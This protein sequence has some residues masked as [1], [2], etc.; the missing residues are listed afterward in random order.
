MSGIT[1]VSALLQTNMPHRCP[2]P[3]FWRKPELQRSS[4]AVRRPVREAERVGRLA[5]LVAW[6]AASVQL[7]GCS[8]PSWLCYFPSGVKK[9]TI[10]TGPDTNG[11]RAIAVD[12]VFVTEDLPAQEIGKLS[13]R[14]FFMRRRQL[15]LD[16]PQSVQIRSWELA[17]GQLVRNADASP[18]CNLVQTYLFA[19]Y[20]S[21]GDHRATLSGGS[22][23][24][25]TL[26]ANDFTIQQ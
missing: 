24:V 19:G 12:L 23:I 25:I 15:L 14:D 26:G 6:L 16:Y 8:T 18:P 20:G 22:S 9:V 5:I 17:P 13:A 1:F 4:Y 2:P 10:V 3:R 21:Q 7:A 11:D